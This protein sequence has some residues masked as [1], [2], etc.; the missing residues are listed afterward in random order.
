MALEMLTACIDNVND[1]HT[2]VIVKPSLDT[3]IYVARID[4]DSLYL[5]SDIKSAEWF[6][7]EEDAGKALNTLSKYWNVGT[8][9]R[10]AKYHMLKDVLCLL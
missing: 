7:H 1:S 9:F 5:C 10:V 3:F 4:S 6:M 2:F 8:S